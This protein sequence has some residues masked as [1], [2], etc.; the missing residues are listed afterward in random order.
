MKIIFSCKICRLCKGFVVCGKKMHTK[1][2]SVIKIRTIRTRACN[3]Q[4]LHL[5]FLQTLSGPASGWTVTFYLQKAGGCCRRKKTGKPIW[6]PSN[7][8]LS[9]SGSFCLAAQTDLCWKSHDWA[10]G[11]LWMWTIN[12]WSLQRQNLFH[13]W[14]WERIKKLKLNNISLLFKTLRMCTFIYKTF[15]FYL[16]E[17]I[18][19]RMIKCQVLSLLICYHSRSYISWCGHLQSVEQTAVKHHPCCKAPSAITSNRHFFVTQYTVHTWH[20]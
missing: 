9:S 18:W 2:Q 12:Q 19:N 11:A 15:I 4:P 16:V 8:Q 3:V 14:V 13:S 20:K 5:G 1:S 6:V 7:T 10:A 17:K